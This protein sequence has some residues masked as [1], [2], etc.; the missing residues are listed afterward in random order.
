MNDLRFPQTTKKI[1]SLRQRSKLFVKLRQNSQT[2]V[3]TQCWR[4]CDG[5]HQFEIYC[6]GYVLCFKNTIGMVPHW[7]SANCSQQRENMRYL[8]TTLGFVDLRHSA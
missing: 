7:Y 1:A 3:G 4:I 6:V 2:V 5:E 8:T